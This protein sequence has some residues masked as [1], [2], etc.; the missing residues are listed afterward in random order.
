MHKLTLRKNDGTWDGLVFE[1]DGQEILNCAKLNLVMTPGELLL[2][3][4][5]DLRAIDVEI[6]GVEI[7]EVIG[8]R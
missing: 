8:L 4:T 3:L 1:I 7:T 2:N 5:L 6:E